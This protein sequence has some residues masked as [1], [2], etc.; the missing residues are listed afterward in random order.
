MEQIRSKST[1]GFFGPPGILQ[2]AGPSEGPK[3]YL[4]LLLVLLILGSIATG[5]VAWRTAARYPK[6]GTIAS[7]VFMLLLC[8]KAVVHWRPDWEVM[9]FPWPKYAYLQPLAI[10][11]LMVSFFGLAAARLKLR[12]NQVL[13]ALIGVVFL[14]YGVWQNSWIAFPEQHGRAVRADREHHCRQSTTY[15]CGPAACVSALDYFGVTV[16]ERSM[17]SLCLTH[18]SGSSTFNLYRGLLLAL[19]ERDFR[20]RI[21]TLAPAD[22]TL[23]GRVVVTATGQGHHAI[24]LLG[25]GDGVTVHDPL[26]AQPRGWSLDALSQQVQG[27]V[28][29]IERI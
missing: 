5:V 19:G 2:Q 3:F 28:I 8:V 27:P 1:A 20:V 29:L 9:L 18:K 4:M 13:V 6:A 11:P 14:G 7:A 15:T 24:C 16:T 26:H 17:A 23:R 25:T 12:W 10:Y 22:L 21:L